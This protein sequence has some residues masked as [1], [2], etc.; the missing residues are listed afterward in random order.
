MLTC[1]QLLAENAALR[2]ESAALRAENADLKRRLGAAIVR[3]AKLEGRLAHELQELLHASLSRTLEDVTFG[4]AAVVRPAER[5]RAACI[6]ARFNRFLT[7]R[8]TPHAWAV[9][10]LGRDASGRE[11]RNVLS[12]AL[13]TQARR[14]AG[15]QRHDALA[16]PAGESDED[17]GAHPGEVRA[18]REAAHGARRRAEAAAGS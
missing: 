15:P 10:S 5:R 14:A 9:C 8:R 7:R 16:P 2:S 13:G 12:A 11:M 18:L 6:A 3:I 1:E 4:E 17:R